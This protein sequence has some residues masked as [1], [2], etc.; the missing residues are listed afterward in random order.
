MKSATTAG[1]PAKI[2]CRDGTLV[3]FDVK[4]IEAAVG[5]AAHEVAYNDPDMPVTVA[6][7]VADTLGCR[8]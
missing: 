6:R 8:G 1:W 4:R 2:R 3:P 5:R 7:A